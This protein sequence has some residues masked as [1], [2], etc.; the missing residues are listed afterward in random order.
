ML[1]AGFYFGSSKGSQ[2]KDATI[3]SQGASLATSVPT[4]VE[5][6]PVLTPALAT[7]TI[8]PGER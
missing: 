6:N 1:A 5:D 3:A 4:S 2:D 8:P 7:T